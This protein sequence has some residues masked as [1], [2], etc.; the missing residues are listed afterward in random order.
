MNLNVFGSVH[1]IYLAITITLS[2]IGLFCA[3]K[4]AKS[5][6]SFNTLK[7]LSKKKRSCSILFLY[8][9]KAI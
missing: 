6:K 5:D 8:S 9:S 7:P 3:K 1:L 2:V 4:F